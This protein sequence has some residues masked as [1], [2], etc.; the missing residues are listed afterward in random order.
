[1]SLLHLFIAWNIANEFSMFFY[2]LFFVWWLFYC[3]KD[4]SIC[5][6]TKFPCKKERDARFAYEPTKIDSFSPP[7]N[8]FQ[9]RSYALDSMKQ[10][11]LI[12]RIFV[13]APL[14]ALSTLNNFRYRFSSC[15]QCVASL[16]LSL[17]HKH[18]TTL[19]GANKV[20]HIANFHPLR[21][22]K[23]RYR[24]RQKPNEMDIAATATK[25][26]HPLW[27]HLRQ[28]YG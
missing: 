14:V 3:M 23:L 12:Y 5:A 16:P 10:S 19:V 26:W 27:L 18:E 13:Y 28:H 22:E 1:M 25:K 21:Q 8:P 7:C 9:A 20:F 6:D 11:A 2:S 15:S 24:Q 4:W 17:H